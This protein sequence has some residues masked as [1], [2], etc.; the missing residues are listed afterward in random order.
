[1]K[2]Y[3][4]LLKEAK[5]KS[6]VMVFGRFNPPTIGHGKL[7]ESAGNIARRFNAELYVYGSQSQDPKKNPL[8]NQQ[9]MNFMKEMFPK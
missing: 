5:A 6:A 7:L 2:T 1:M 9:K 3:K 4:S 8:S